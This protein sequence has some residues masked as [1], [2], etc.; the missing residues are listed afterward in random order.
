MRK[1]TPGS[2]KQF[3]TSWSAFAPCR[4]SIP[5]CVG[6]NKTEKARCTFNK[7]TEEQE[8]KSWIW[9]SLD[10]DKPG[11]SFMNSPGTVWE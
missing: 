8:D 9:P 4:R 1:Y 6:V 5:F 7:E 10:S 3:F 11:S 2:L